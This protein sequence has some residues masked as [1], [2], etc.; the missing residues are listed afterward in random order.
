M[1]SCYREAHSKTFL[2]KH[3]VV[4]RILKSLLMLHSQERRSLGSIRNGRRPDLINN[5]QMH[6][7][8][9][10]GVEPLLLLIM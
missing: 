3:F 6:S 9:I 5:L 7:S 10:C 1:S 4:L 8:L 2:I